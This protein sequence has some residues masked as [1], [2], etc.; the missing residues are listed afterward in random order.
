LGSSF[1]YVTQEEGPT[2]Q[3]KF[4]ELKKSPIAIPEKGALTGS[5][6]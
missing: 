4:I 3:P 5:V 1:S 6:L 2:E